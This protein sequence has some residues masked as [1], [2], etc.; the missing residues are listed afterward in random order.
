[1]NHVGPSN[2]PI[3][4]DG[5]PLKLE[6]ITRD[7]SSQSFAVAIATARSAVLMQGDVGGRWRSPVDGL[8]NWGSALMFPLIP[9]NAPSELNTRACG[10]FEKFVELQIGRAS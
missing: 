4:A 3:A 8:R 10:T 6:S 2:A 9:A 1:M 7:C 5:M